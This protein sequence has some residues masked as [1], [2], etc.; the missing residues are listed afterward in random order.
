MENIAK[1]GVATIDREKF[2]VRYGWLILAVSALLGLVA[3]IY[4]AVFPAPVDLP[5]VIN[6]TGQSWTDIVAQSPAAVKLTRYFISAFWIADAAVYALGLAIAVTAYRQGM[7]WAWY[8]SWLVVVYGL[9]FIATSAAAGG[10]MW[11]NWI[12]HLSLEVLGLILP[13]RKFFPKTTYRSQL[14]RS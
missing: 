9:V 6:L 11:A 2:Y 13:Y 4:L 7:R 3:G 12:V 1:T 8:V 5:G 14:S 10:T